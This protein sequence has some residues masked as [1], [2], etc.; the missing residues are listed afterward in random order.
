MVVSL[1][2]TVGMCWFGMCHGR[3]VHGWV[4]QLDTSP[5]TCHWTVEVYVPQV[6]HQGTTVVFYTYVPQDR[7]GCSPGTVKPWRKCLGILGHA[8]IRK[9]YG[10]L[11]STRLE[12]ELL[13]NCTELHINPGLLDSV[14][15]TP[16]LRPDTKPHCDV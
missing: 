1:H 6:P 7:S 4:R 15:A 16:L 12:D 9:M 10:L 3:D 2:T 11:L 13:C 8:F 14:A 5:S